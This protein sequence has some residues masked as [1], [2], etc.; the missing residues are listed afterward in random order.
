MICF[1]QI[2][3]QDSKS[4]PVYTRNRKT[5][6]I[7]LPNHKIILPFGFTIHPFNKKEYHHKGVDLPTLLST[8]ILAA[9]DGH[10][11]IVNDSVLS[12]GYGCYIL[13]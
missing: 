3:L 13:I 6:S 2:T 11:I 8:P 1:S 10:V 9:A 7:F 12:K 5:S 4:P